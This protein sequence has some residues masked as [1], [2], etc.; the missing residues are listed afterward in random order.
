MHI[1]HLILFGI[2]LRAYS[3]VTATGSRTVARNDITDNVYNLTRSKR[4]SKSA[5]ACAESLCK[6]Q[7]QLDLRTHSFGFFYNAAVTIGGEDFELNIDTGSHVT[8][9]AA[10]DFTCSDDKGKD[11]LPQEK[12]RSGRLF[13]PNKPA[14]QPVGQNDLIGYG[15]GSF[16]SGE[17]GKVR[18]GI[19]G[20]TIKQ[21]IIAADHVSVKNDGICSGVLGL[22]YPTEMAFGRK[23]EKSTSVLYTLFQNTSIPPI[24][25]LTLNRYSIHDPTRSA[26]ILA[27]GGIPSIPTNKHWVQTPIVPHTT[28]IGMYSINIDGITIMPPSRPSRKSPTKQGRQNDG[29]HIQSRLTMVIDSGATAITLPSEIVS[30]FAS[31]FLPPAYYDESAKLY[32]V[33]C[34]ALPAQISIQIAGTTYPIARE[35]LILHDYANG[36]NTCFIS[37]QPSH[38]GSL[39]LGQPWLKSVLV[40]FDMRGAAWTHRKAHRKAH[41]TALGLVRIASRPKY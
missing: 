30:H 6:S 2:S 39:M 18:L 16:A 38:H 19:G 31:L 36:A 5:Y 15:D 11:V 21:T 32:R 34:N 26:G 7:L 37:I 20:N 33:L 35:D 40:A 8:W 3:V 41:R 23:E 27:F 10:T 17:K 14:F 4:F 12:C 9:V 25:S 13:N 22:S 28:G 1:L 29:L 24:L